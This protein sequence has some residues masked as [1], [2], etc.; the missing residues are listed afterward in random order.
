MSI[1]EQF[2][3]G[4]NEV[5]ATHVVYPHGKTPARFSFIFSEYRQAWLT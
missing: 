5:R 4:R 2:L 3:P 1:V